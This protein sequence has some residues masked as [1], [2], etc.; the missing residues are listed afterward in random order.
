MSNKEAIKAVLKDAA[1]YC[2]PSNTEDVHL[3]TLATFLAAD[4]V[5]CVGRGRKSKVLRSKDVWWYTP[6]PWRTEGED[7]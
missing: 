2:L 6:K 4:G 5:L 7:E 1:P 3:E